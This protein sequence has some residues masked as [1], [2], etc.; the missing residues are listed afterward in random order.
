MND[1]LVGRILKDAYRVDKPL[2]DG[3]MSLVYLAWQIS[4][5]RPVVLKVLRPGFND[6]DFIELF[7]REARICSQINHPNVVS[8]F[9]FGQTEDGV[10][11]LAMELLEGET[12]GD[13]VSSKGGLP[14]AKTVWLMEQVCNGVHAAHKQNVVH[15][16]LKPNNIMI[17][18]VSGGDTIAKVLDF[19]ISKPLAEED[20]KHTRLG[21]VM[22]TPGYLSPEQIEGQRKIDPRADIYA[23]GAILYFSLTGV[24]PFKGANREIIMGKQLDE[25]PAPLSSFE[26]LDP[27]CLVLQGVIDKAMH[28]DKAHRYSTVKDLWNDIFSNAVVSPAELSDL[29]VGGVTHYQFIFS[30]RMKDGKNL[31]E[32]VKRIKDVL[33]FNEKQ[34]LSLI[35]GK[36]VIVR[37]NLSFKDAERFQSIF[38][39]VGLLGDVEEMPSATRIAPRKDAS[40]PTAS[41]VEPVTLEDIQNLTQSQLVDEYHASLNT[42]AADLESSGYKMG[43]FKKNKT[44][45]GQHITVG[46]VVLVMLALSSFWFYKPLH[47]KVHDFWLYTVLGK[48]DARGVSENNIKIGMSASF[49]GSAKEL[50]RSMKIGIETYFASVNERGGIHGRTLQLVARNDS[51][52]PEQA[53]KNVK[54]FLDKDKGVLA[55]LGNVGTPTA[56][57]ILPMVLEHNSLLIG[58]LSGA[59]LLRNSPPDR[60]VFNYRA[61]YAEETEEIVH[62]FVKVKEIDP[63]RIAIF[64]QNDSFGEDG[65][66]GVERA[67]AEYNVEPS[68]ILRVIY[69]RNTAQVDNAVIELSRQLESI[70]AVVVVATYSASAAFTY[71]MRTAGFWGDIA[72]VSFVGA[73]ALSELLLEMG[74]EFVED[75]LVTQVVPLY[76]SYSSGVLKYRAD[77]KRYYP[78][79]EPDFVSL[80]GYI[81]AAIFCEALTR[82]GRYFTEEELVNKLEATKELD[83]G[84]GSLISFSPSDHQGSDRVW[85]SVIMA[86]G[87]FQNVDLD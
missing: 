73:R 39:K 11:Y 67:L 34:Y 55:M 70:D 31:E 76:N 32:S 33:K 8:V 28:I 72:N 3:G 43:S 62:Y 59:S 15:R 63:K 51:Y 81:V 58:S 41:G 78:N 77:I 75:I 84:I 37:K 4:L 86:D 68:D 57:A 6:E 46:F 17:S 12:L 69:E 48:Q 20:L 50:G 71:Q 80:E 29:L 53:K 35:S 65:V 45:R 23:L 38:G 52:E 36:R 2:A 82:S 25:H 27:E 21:M 1:P 42:Q 19:G 74:P 24:N 7:L 66:M 14:L 13:I 10:V 64:Y 9:D 18:K 30:G 16:D 49:S 54:T 85:G 87:S 83:L 22:G 47:Y 61:S 60:Y 40:M 44:R 5:S 79:E 26:K 56:K